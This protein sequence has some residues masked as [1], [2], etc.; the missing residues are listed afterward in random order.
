MSNPELAVQQLKALRELGIRISIDDFGTGYSSLA[1]LKR[2]PIHTLKLDRS[3]VRDIEIDPN[4][5]E[6]CSATIAL[7][8]NL[9]LTVVAEGVETEM[10][11]DYLM[12]HGC[13]YLQGYYFSKPLPADEISRFIQS[14]Y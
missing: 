14:S 12:E 13:D 5:A 2:L 6:I 9:G 7:A 10:Q 4:D 8:H 1:Y 3:F 11:R